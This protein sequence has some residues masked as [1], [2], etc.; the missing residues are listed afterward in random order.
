LQWTER[1]EAKV[2]LQRSEELIGGRGHDAKFDS[3]THT[4]ASARSSATPNSRS[5]IGREIPDMLLGVP[6]EIRFR[7]RLYKPSDV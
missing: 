6:S 7:Q 5:P 1:A 4:P 3:K 2:L